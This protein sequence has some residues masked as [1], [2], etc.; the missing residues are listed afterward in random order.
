MILKCQPFTA[1]SCRQSF[2]RKKIA[3]IINEEKRR[4]LNRAIKNLSEAKLLKR[5]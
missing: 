2:K 5:R 4:A 1:K 3:K